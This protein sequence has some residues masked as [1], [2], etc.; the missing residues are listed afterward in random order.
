MSWQERKTHEERFEPSM[1]HYIHK[2]LDQLES[3]SRLHKGCTSEKPTRR[4]L[5]IDQ[6]KPEEVGS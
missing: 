1:A 6:H 2:G 5:E 4:S 3:T